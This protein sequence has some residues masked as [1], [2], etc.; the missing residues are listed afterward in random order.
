MSELDHSLLKWIAGDM[1][2]WPP[3]G[4]EIAEMAKRLMDYPLFR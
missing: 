3:I 4:T 1:S 2:G